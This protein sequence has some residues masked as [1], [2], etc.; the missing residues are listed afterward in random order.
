[1]PC[2]NEVQDF[3]IYFQSNVRQTLACSL[4]E[5]AHVIGPEQTEQDLIHPFNNFI[6]DIDS[7]KIGLLKNLSKFLQVHLFLFSNYYAEVFGHC[8]SNR[9]YNCA[10]TFQFESHFICDLEICNGI[11]SV[12]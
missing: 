1:M 3:T 9:R 11:I 10:A 6:Y 12:L 7:V 5:I 4:H 2:D 8:F